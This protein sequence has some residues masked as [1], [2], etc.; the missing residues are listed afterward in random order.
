[1]CCSPGRCVKDDDRQSNADE[2]Y[3]DLLLLA[4]NLINWFKRLCLPPEFQNATLQT[5]RERGL[6]ET[7]AGTNDKARFRRSVTDTAKW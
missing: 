3:F 6:V 7:V 2:T 5:L 1:M 4:Y